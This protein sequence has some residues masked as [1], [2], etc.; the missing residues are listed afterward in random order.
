MK[1][2]LSLNYYRKYLKYKRKCNLIKIQLYGGF[3]STWEKRV[4]PTIKEDNIYE[5][6][7]LMKTISVNKQ[8]QQYADY[9]NPRIYSGEGYNVKNVCYNDTIP[10]KDK[11]YRLMLFNVH[12]F[13]KQCGEEGEIKRDYKHMY[14]FVSDKEIDYLLLTEMAPIKKRRRRSE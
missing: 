2:K 3:E 12:N 9:K 14:N 8:Y 4:V 13:V 6:G 1:N 10:K 5:D 7:E 11:Q